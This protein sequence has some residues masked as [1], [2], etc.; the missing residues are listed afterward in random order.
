MGVEAG[1]FIVKLFWNKS[2]EKGLGLRRCKGL[3]AEG[4]YGSCVVGHFYLI[5]TLCREALRIILA[6]TRII[7]V[8]SFFL[9]SK[10]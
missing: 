3:R 4:V 2:G 6:L 8:D 1:I 9:L 7:L 5:S 10:K